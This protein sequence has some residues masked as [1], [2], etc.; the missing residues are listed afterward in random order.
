MWSRSV[1]QFYQVLDIFL[2]L[3]AQEVVEL[4]LLEKKLEALSLE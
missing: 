4:Y 3:G 2:P 1:W